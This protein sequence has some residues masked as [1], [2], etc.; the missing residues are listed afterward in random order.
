[1][2]HSS[3]TS[4]YQEWSVEE[5]IIKARQ[6]HAGPADDF[7]NPCQDSC[8]KEPPHSKVD[9]LYEVKNYIGSVKEGRA[10]TGGGWR[11]A[12]AGN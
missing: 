5:S 10:M 1:M 7:T 3:S 8:G 11:V 2:K 12:H 9:S 4:L 6:K